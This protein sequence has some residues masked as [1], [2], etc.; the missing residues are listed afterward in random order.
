MT[1]NSR[2][3]ITIFRNK[4]SNKVLKSSSMSPENFLVDEERFS[5]SKNT[6]SSDNLITDFMLKLKFDLINISL[7]LKVKKWTLEI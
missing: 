6:S 2:I 1:K 5:N 3:P 4:E 7:P